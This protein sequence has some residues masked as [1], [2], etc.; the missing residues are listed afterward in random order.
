MKMRIKC[1]CGRFFSSRLSISRHYPSCVARSCHAPN[2]NVLLSQNIALGN[3]N[4]YKFEDYEL[5]SVLD[6]DFSVGISDNDSFSS[7]SDKLSASIPLLLEV[8]T[9]AA[10]YDSNGVNDDSYSNSGDVDDNVDN[11]DDDDDDDDDDN[12]DDDSNEIHNDDSDNDTNDDD[13]DDDDDIGGSHM[14]ISLNVG[15]EYFCTTFSLT[16]NPLSA[17]FKIQIQMNEI[18]DKNKASLCMYDD[19]NLLFYKPISR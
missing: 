8:K 12:D 2:N 9:D 15:E 1:S 11:N 4:E 6:S 5:E 14:S 13:D 18:F 10:H 7:N 17:A 16:P 3:T 19:T